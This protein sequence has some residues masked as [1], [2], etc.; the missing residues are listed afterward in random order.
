MEF[1]AFAPHRPGATM[2]NGAYVVSRA[3]MGEKALVVGHDQQD[4]GRALGRH[5][6]RRPLGFGILGA[7]LDYAAEFWRRRRELIA[8][9]SRGNLFSG[10]V[11]TG[12]RVQKFT[13][14]R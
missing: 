4:V 14:Q 2:N 3:A 8:V 1:P 11:D 9:D 10:D 6:T 12:K 5:D 13:P 7:F